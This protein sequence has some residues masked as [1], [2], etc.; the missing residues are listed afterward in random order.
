MLFINLQSMLQS[1]VLALFGLHTTLFINTHYK[2]LMA[3]V[4]NNADNALPEW[5]EENPVKVFNDENHEYNSASKYYKH[6]LREYLINTNKNQHTVPKIHNW[7]QKTLGKRAWK[8]GTI[9]KYIKEIKDEIALDDD[10]ETDANSNSEI[11]LNNVNDA[12]DATDATEAKSDAHEA[13]S[14][15]SSVKHRNSVANYA[16]AITNKLMKTSPTDGDILQIL[17]KIGSQNNNELKKRFN[18]NLG[19]GV[20]VANNI[21]KYLKYI[22]SFKSP[23]AKIQ[24][25]IL[26]AAMLNSNE[27]DVHATNVTQ[28]VVRNSTGL[29]SKLVVDAFK[30]RKNWDK[31]CTKEKNRQIE[32]KENPD[33]Q[34]SL[35]QRTK[36][37]LIFDYDKNKKHIQ[38]FDQKVQ[39]SIVKFWNET[40]VP[41]PSPYHALKNRKK[42]LY[43]PSTGNI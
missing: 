31:E 26:A 6:Q 9:I 13:V 23:D 33:R 35:R 20:S 36:P 5:A 10:Q 18:I 25:L 7:F 4:A 17:N 15:S 19:D 28:Y 29:N 27:N 2:I 24:K 42:K 22:N 40:T 37:I 30:L 41:D 34:Q 14:R 39:N 11:D 3:S 38:L 43:T 16:T 8:P 21:I 1:L 32:E 12:T